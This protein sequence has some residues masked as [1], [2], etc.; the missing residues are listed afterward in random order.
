ME[1]IKL[2]LHEKDDVFLK[3]VLMFIF[4]MFL[5]A[6]LVACGGD[7][8]ESTQSKVQTVVS[9]ISSTVSGFISDAGSYVS[10]FVSDISNNENDTSI[11][12]SESGDVS[13]A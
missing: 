6:S 4:A 8:V 13:A 1:R 12:G 10:S 5:G 11:T 7:N 3:K 2:S 9:E